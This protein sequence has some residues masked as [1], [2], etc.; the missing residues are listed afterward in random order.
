[1]FRF[2]YKASFYIEE[3]LAPSQNPKL[4]DH[5][6]SAVRDCLFNIFEATLH[7]GG[8][9]SIRNTRTRHAVVTRTYLSWLRVYY[10]YQFHPYLVERVSQL[11]RVMK[12]FVS[13]VIILISE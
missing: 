8:L 10:V 11:T 2:R 5:P 7:I 3:L 12:C 4:E 13:T 6:L 1:V 9:S